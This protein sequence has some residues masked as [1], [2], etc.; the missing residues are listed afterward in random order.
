[1]PCLIAHLTFVWISITL[2]FRHTF[3]LDIALVGIAERYPANPF[4][5][6]NQLGFESSGVIG[7][8]LHGGRKY[9]A[10]K[11]MPDR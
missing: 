9:L 2:A 10:E 1:M 5:H 7:L 3:C 6:M 8:Q 11:K 4:P